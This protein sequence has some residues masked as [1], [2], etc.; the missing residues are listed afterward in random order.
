MS[1][2][3]AKVYQ[4]ALNQLLADQ[5]HVLIRGKGGGVKTTFWFRERLPDDIDDTFNPYHSLCN[6]EAQALEQVRDLLRAIQDGQ[7]V[8]N[9]GNNTYY[10]LTLSGASGRVM[11][12]DWMEGSFTDLL[13]AVTTWFDAFAIVHRTGQGMAPAPKFWAVLGALVRDLADLPAPVVSKL[14]R[15]ALDP[16]APIPHQQMAQ[17]LRR[18]RIDIVN[19]DPS[20]HARIGLL[21]AYHVRK[22]DPH[23]KPYLNEDHP[24]VAYQC[25]RLMAVLA[26]IQWRALGDVGAGVIQRYYG[27]ASATPALVF[28]R[29]LR[30]SQHHIEKLRKNKKHLYVEGKLAEIAGKIQDDFPA[31]FSLEQQSLFGLGYYQQKAADRVQYQKKNTNDESTPVEEKEND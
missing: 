26:D 29:L 28:G 30:N 27:A 20:N 21:K 7:R 9:L 15:V 11:V 24:S 31:T 1:E 17:A 5:S 19:D 8:D 14:W 12:R 3:Q 25:G 23:M 4:Q 18:L 6:A 2:A 10:A 13:R 22:G 16:D